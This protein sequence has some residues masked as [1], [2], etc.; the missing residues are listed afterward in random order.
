MAKEQFG[1]VMVHVKLVGVTPLL[2][3]R[4]DIQVLNKEID[5]S[6]MEPEEQAAFGTYTDDD[7]NPVVPLANVT[8]ALYEITAGQKWPGHG[9]TGL[10]KLVPYI[11][12]RPPIQAALID[13]E[14]GKPPKPQLNQL[15]IG[16]G[17]VKS[18]A[19]FPSW[20]IEFE[21]GLL[22]GLMG[23]NKSDAMALVRR[24]FEMAGI[25]AGLMSF[26]PAKKGQYG[27]FQVAE[28][29]EL[30]EK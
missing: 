24:M 28:F 29:S 19:E 25:A 11:D 10:T 1:S 3:D 26:R 7:G 14:N 9:R 15:A 4:R 2:M 18:R 27:K 16:I 22:H 21:I 13:P 12:F 20:Q 6:K 23:M 8:A 30:N 17:K 5:P